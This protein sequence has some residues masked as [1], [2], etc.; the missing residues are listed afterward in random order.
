LPI[1]EGGVKIAYETTPLGCKK[2]TL[3]GE[4][5]DL[6]VNWSL[7]FLVSA[8]EFVPAF[9]K[10]T[11]FVILS[12]SMSPTLIKKLNGRD[13]PGASSARPLGTL[14]QLLQIVCQLLGS[15]RM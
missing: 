11:D 5:I 4:L 8:A 2:V 15:G 9:L 13:W 10:Q 1:S 6:G 3:C 7:K 14:S 12:D